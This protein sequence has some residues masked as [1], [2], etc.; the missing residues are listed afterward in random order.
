MKTTLETVKR[1]NHRDLKQLNYIQKT[2]WRIFSLHGCKLVEPPIFE[3]Y[4][5]YREIFP[6]LRKDFLKIV[7]TDGSVMV[8]RP[9]VTVGV[10]KYLAEDMEYMPPNAY[11]KLAYIT[12]V[13]LSSRSLQQGGAAFLQ[14][15]AEIFGSTEPDCDSEVI[16]LGVNCLQAL[17]IR[18]IQIDLGSVAYSHAFLQMLQLPE[19]GIQ[20]CKE[21]IEERK[22][23]ALEELSEQYGL[24]GSLKETLLSFP[25][26]FGPYKEALAKAEKLCCNVG[27]KEALQRL[28]IICEQLR[29]FLPEEMIHLDFAF[30]NRQHYYTDMLFKIY[31]TGAAYPLVEGGRYD[32]LSETLGTVR[33]ACGFGINISLLQDYLQEHDLCQAETAE[34]DL[35]ICYQTMTQALYTDI[36]N[37]RKQGFK[38]VATPADRETD[39]SSYRLVCTW[40]DG[41]Y[42]ENGQSYD[43]KTLCHKLGEI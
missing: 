36:V 32:K 7:D 13:F 5:L 9:D 31:V 12:S 19:E 39:I 21:A 37:F 4:E 15:G 1:F 40:Q 38:V 10:A 26:L 22:L 17:A 27:M 35:N 29:W 11:T 16:M 23:D 43:F 8:L 42:R 18:D 6:H 30:S 2:L 33:P 41:K 25:T 3:D 34:F 14:G 20:L 28:Q 24:A